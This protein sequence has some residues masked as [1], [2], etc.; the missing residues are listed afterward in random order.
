MGFSTQKQLLLETKFRFVTG[1][2]GDPVFQTCGNIVVSGEYTD[3]AN[4][5]LL[6]VYPIDVL[7]CVGN[8][9]IRSDEALFF[10]L[11]ESIPNGS[12]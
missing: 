8:I 6:E 3:P 12:G 7:P 4:K 11:G 2:A 5:S 10:Q 9:D 1:S